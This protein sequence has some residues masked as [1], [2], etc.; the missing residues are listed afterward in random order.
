MTSLGSFFRA[1]RVK[2]R[3]SWLLLTA[4]LAPLCQ[5]G[6]LAVIFW[7]SES[8]IRMFKPG[9]QFWLE[10]NFA[11]WNLVIMPVITALVC[12]LSWEQERE[13]RAW[14]LL[15]IQPVPHHTHYLVKALGHLVLL[16]MSL[17]LLAVLLAFGGFFLRNQP[18]LLMGPLPLVTFVQF[19]TYSALA[20][21]AVVAFQ[22]WLSMRIP[23][24]WIGL[25]AAIAGS[26]FTQRLVGGSALV[27]LLPW[28]LAAHMALM[29]ERWRVLPWIYAAGSL[30]SAGALVAL[31]A[32]DFTRH[33]EPRS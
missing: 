24:L 28:G 19:T 30:L 26:W 23:G 6:F 3:K 12:E 14:N 21:V 31:G 18:G 4:I 29:F 2:W 11:A 10:L 1:E 5:T 33:H 16:L 32:F 13:A 7:F 20:L 25:A 27:Q 9:F 15:L 22:T 8:R 17:S